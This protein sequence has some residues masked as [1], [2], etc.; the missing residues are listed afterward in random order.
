MTGTT[1]DAPGAIGTPASRLVVVGSSAGGLEALTEFLGAIEPGLDIAYVVAQHLAPTHPSLLVELLAP[2]TR[3]HVQLAQE[4]DVLVPDIVLVI[5]PDRDVELTRNAIRMT[6][7]EARMSPRPS[8]DRL[9]QSAAD[10]WGE[11]LTAV[12]LSGTGSDGAHGLRSVHAAGG[13]TLVQSPDTARFSG[14]PEAAL[15]MGV[16]DLVADPRELGARLSAMDPRTVAGHAP[17]VKA[18]DLDMLRSIIAQLR[19]LLGMDF[20]GYKEST[21]NRQVRRR[22]AICQTESLEDYFA[23]LAKDPEEAQRLADNLLVTVTSFFRD[24]MPSLLFVRR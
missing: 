10:A 13:L 4:G 19:R 23:L 3:L 6:Q 22:M 17:E 2:A 16:V 15:A 8:I 7:P 11:T 18:S 1:P 20:S 24:P 9:F 14:M 21:V 5:P 12:V